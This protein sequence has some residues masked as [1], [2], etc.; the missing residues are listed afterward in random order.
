MCYV[1][2]VCKQNDWI[3]E[4][5][6]TSHMCNDCRLFIEMHTLDKPLEIMF[7]DGHALEAAGKG[8]VMLDMRLP[9]GNTQRCKFQDVLYIPS[10]SYNLLSVSKA[11]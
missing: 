8:I 10:L 4:S 1:S 3:V 6:A 9:N 2:S 11:A 5:G 7:G